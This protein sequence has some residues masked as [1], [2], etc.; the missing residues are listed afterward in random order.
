[1]DFVGSTFSPRL[2][3]ELAIRLLYSTII[4][5]IIIIIISIILCVSC[6]RPGDRELFVHLT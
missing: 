2:P 5:I 4:I 1:M 3:I 6:V